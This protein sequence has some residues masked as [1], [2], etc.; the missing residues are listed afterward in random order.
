M[1]SMGTFQPVPPA[2]VSRV[3]ATFERRQLEGFIA[4]ALDL[5]DLADGDPD[6]ENATDT[7]DDFA[8][9]PLAHYFTSGPGCTVSD[10]GG[11]AEGE[12]DEEDD[13]AGQMDE[14]GLNTGYDRARMAE[15]A[16][17]EPSRV[18]PLWPSQPAAS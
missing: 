5:L 6:L 8:L 1:G 4:V 13:P 15:D 7:E 3:L 18:P 10:P 16:D 14:D 17:A 2:A 11:A 12:D 9:S